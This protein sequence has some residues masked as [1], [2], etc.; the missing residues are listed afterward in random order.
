MAMQSATLLAAENRTLR[1]ANEK[2]RKKRQKKKAYVRRGGVL[3]AAE[4]QEAQIEPTIEVEVGMQ[5]VEP[6]R[7]EA[8]IREPRKCSICRSLEHTARTCSQRLRT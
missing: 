7:T 2:V 1:A 5:V 4:V 8:P 3:S 6:P